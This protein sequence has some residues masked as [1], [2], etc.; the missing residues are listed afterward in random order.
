MRT[1]VLI[2]WGISSYFGW[3]VYG[4]NLALHWANDPN[5]QPVC[6][7][8]IKTS[9]I[10]VDP[11]R[12]RLL[13]QFFEESA[14]FDQRLKD[15]V[16]TNPSAV[17]D[18]P[19]LMPLGDDFI[20][21]P[22]AYNTR[23][24]GRPTIGVTFFENADL[25]PE[26]IKRACEYNKIITGSGWNESVLRGYGLNNV[27]TVLQGV[28]PTLFHPASRSG[29]FGQKFL[30]FSGGKLEFRKGQDLVIR[31]F[32][33]FGKRHSD[34]VLVTAWHSP[35]PQTARTLD[36][37]PNLPSVHTTNDGRIDVDGWVREN[38]IPA[39][40]FLDLGS[41]PNSQLPQ[42]LRE[43]DVGL[44][45][46]RCEGG[47]NLVAM[48]CMA[49]GMPVI[50]SANTGHLDLIKDGNCL[51]LE[52]QTPVKRIQDQAEIMAG[53]GESSVAEIVE[54][55][56][57]VYHEREAAKEIGLRGANMLSQMTWQ[58][59]ADLIKKLVLKHAQ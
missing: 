12:Y 1:Q 3:G 25:K 49:C 59:T 15:Y 41:I 33:E 7:R 21:L 57:R 10:T 22:T 16:K 58:K 54:Q 40:Q 42:I 19:L 46:N 37:V 52:Q 32:A 4:L 30:V 51:P 6:S 53:W 47:T 50:L 35:W 20:G 11:L 28:D 13:Q 45:P 18:V 24:E 48:E 9:G 27:E 38:G 31:A 44:F 39:D 23:I 14:K 26:A 8:P 17:V 34:A 55:L 5:I 2:H 43:M 56:E 29:M 36:S